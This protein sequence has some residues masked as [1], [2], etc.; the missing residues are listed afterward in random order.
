LGYSEVGAVQDYR[1]YAFGQLLSY[2]HDVLH[3]PRIRLALLDQIEIP[4]NERHPI[5]GAACGG[6]RERLTGRRTVNVNVITSAS[7][8]IHHALEEA[9]LIG[10]AEF[11]TLDPHVWMIGSVNTTRLLGIVSLHYPIVNRHDAGCTGVDGSEGE[12][13]HPAE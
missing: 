10:M 4:Q 11:D 8:L 3:A 9:P 12:T 2:W 5:L 7:P 6:V 1:G 13:A